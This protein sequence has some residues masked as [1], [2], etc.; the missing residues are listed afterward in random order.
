MAEPL[1]GSITAPEPL[2]MASSCPFDELRAEMRLF[3]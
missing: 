2:E 1:I 3:G